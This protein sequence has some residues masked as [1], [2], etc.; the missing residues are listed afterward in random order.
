M[1]KLTKKSTAP[2]P[3]PP[4]DDEAPPVPAVPP[5]IDPAKWEDFAVFRET[6]LVYFSEPSNNDALRAVGNLIYL[7]A[8][9]YWQHWPDQPEGWIRGQLRAAVADL[10][11]LEGFL[12]TLGENPPDDAYEKALCRTSV[13][14]SAEVGSVAEQ[15]EAKLGTW[16]GEDAS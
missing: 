13:L 10:R 2:P 11:H 8:L 4:D 7:M 12:S 15:I 3:A 6:F 5:L 9:E 1:P 14:M 16:R